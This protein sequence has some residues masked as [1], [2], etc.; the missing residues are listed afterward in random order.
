MANKF[1]YLHYCPSVNPASLP[2][3]HPHTHPSIHS[4]ICQIVTVY[5]LH[6]SHKHAIWRITNPWVCYFQENGFVWERAWPA[7][8]YFYSW[9]QF[10]RNLTWNL[11]LIQRTSTPLQ[12]PMD[13]LLCLPSTRSASFHCEEER[14]LWQ[15]LCCHLPL[16][17]SGTLLTSSW[18]LEYPLW[19]RLSQPAIL[20][21]SSEHP[22][23]TRVSWGSLHTFI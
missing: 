13:L 2:L 9:P 21:I 4:I 14:T 17:S 19:P 18:S 8:S 15:L 5:S 23:S 22:T 16:P 7:W 10:Y 6:A 12:L 1:V 3:I 20:P 11:W